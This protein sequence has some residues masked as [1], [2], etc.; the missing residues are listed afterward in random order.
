MLFR[1]MPVPGTHD[2]GAG[3]V[4]AGDAGGVAV[5]VQRGDVRRGPEPLP[6]GVRRRPRPCRHDLGRAR[7]RRAGDRNSVAN[8]SSCSRSWKSAPRAGPASAITSTSSCSASG[9]SNG[10]AAPSRSSRSSANAIRMPPD[11]GGGLVSTSQAAVGRDHRLSLDHLVGREVVRGQQAAALGDPLADPLRRLAAVQ[12]VRPI[13]RQ[14]APARRRD[15]GSADR[16][17]VV[18]IR[19]SGAYSARRLRVLTSGSARGSGTRT[20]VR[21]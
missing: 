12:P 3:A 16:S 1:W 21:A 11:D 10:D 5:R 17:P 6:A 20:R 8:P 9:S 19:P 13:G 18:S 4:R 2:A 15:P 7:S 14:P